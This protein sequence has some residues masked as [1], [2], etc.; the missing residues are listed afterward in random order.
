MKLHVVLKGYYTIGY[1][2][3]LGVFK[4]IDAAKSSVEEIP[5]DE[6]EWLEI[7][8]TNLGEVWDGKG[9]KEIM[10]KLHSSFDGSKNSEWYIDET[11]DDE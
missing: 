5:L 4:T 8:T 9:S 11:D 3:V 1:T 6:G 7:W 10:Y 2:K